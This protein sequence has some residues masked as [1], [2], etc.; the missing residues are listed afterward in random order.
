M[1]ENKVK[2][3]DILLHCCC[4]P[5]STTCIEELI[6]DGYNIILWFSNDNIYPKE[7]NEKRFAELIKLAR[8]HNLKVIRNS[9][10]HDKWLAAVSGLENEK[11]GG[12]RC[13]ICFDYNLNITHKKAL[14]LGI[15]YFT[16]TLTVSR[17]K[18]SLKIFEVG[19]KY[20]GFVEKNFK[21]KNGYARSIKLS[22]DLNLYRQ[23]YCG[24]EF[25]LRDALLFEKQRAEKSKNI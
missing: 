18:N 15:K 3:E 17:Y 2:N 13:S 21:K 6:D 22:K 1:Q 16:T 5:C 4:A 25:S 10:D 20:S 19:N 8:F 11:E 12:E 24:C 9:Y 7:E 23:K 14:E